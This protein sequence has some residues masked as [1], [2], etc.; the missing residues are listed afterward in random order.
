MPGV[1]TDAALK[2]AKIAAQEI[3]VD[4]DT[5]KS[6]VGD[7]AKAIAATT[8]PHKKLVEPAAALIVPRR[9]ITKN[10]TD[11]V[12]KALADV[13]GVVARE[14][15]AG[16]GEVIVTLDNQGGARLADITNALKKLGD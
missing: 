5:T 8:T 3:T 15:S 7:V 6:D 4:L 16:Q 1:K 14:A 9:G 2:P 10:D 13:K 11:K 12:R